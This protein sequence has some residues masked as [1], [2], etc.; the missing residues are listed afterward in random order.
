MTVGEDDAF[1]IV[2]GA[3]I[4]GSTPASVALFDGAYTGVETDRGVKIELLC[5]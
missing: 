3:V 4:E 2:G 1:I 5:E